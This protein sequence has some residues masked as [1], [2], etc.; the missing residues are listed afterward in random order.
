ME[1][2]ERHSSRSR[3]SRVSREKSSSPCDVVATCHSLLEVYVLQSYGCS[4]L[5]LGCPMK[6]RW[7][8]ILLMV[9]SENISTLTMR[10]TSLL[11]QGILSFVLA[12]ME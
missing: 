3:Q 4:T 10:R 5:A 7:K 1:E 11:I 8:D 12:P 9:G 6:D 2:E